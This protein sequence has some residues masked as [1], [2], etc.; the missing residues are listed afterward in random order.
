MKITMGSNDNGEMY[1]SLRSNLVT[2]VKIIQS[3]IDELPL[4]VK[5]KEKTSIYETETHLSLSGSDELF[6][7]QVARV[8][9]SGAILNQEK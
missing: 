8:G 6:K 2:R 5:V 4:L 9:G 3:V 7:D 1:L